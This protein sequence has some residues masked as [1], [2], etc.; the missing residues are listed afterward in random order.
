MTQSYRIKAAFAGVGIAALLSSNASAG[1]AKVVIDDKAP[2]AASEWSY[3][4]LFKSNT[5]Y[6]SDSGPINKIKWIG[7]YHG[8]YHSTDSNQGADSDWQNRRFR[9]GLQIEFLNDFKF[10]GQFNLKTD[11]SAGGRFVDSVEDLTIEWE[12]SDDF[13]VIVGKQKAKTTSDWATSSKQILTFERSLLTNQVVPDKIGGVVVGYNLTEKLWVEG[14]VFSG[15]WTDDGWELPDFNG[16]IAA[17]ARIGY[18]FNDATEL[19]FGYFYG[20]GAGEDTGIEEYDNVFVWSTVSS[21]GKVGLTTDIIYATGIDNSH[22]SDVFGLVIM[23]S[24]DIT[25]KLQAVFRY[26]YAQSESDSG[27]RLQSRYERAGDAAPLNTRGDSYNAFY[28]GL[29]YRLCGDNLKLM[30]GIEYADLAAPSAEDWDGF[31]YMAG[32]RLYF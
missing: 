12:P 2:V 8:Q 7:R 24:Y 28:L 23:P 20:E 32:V 5:L 9:A 25:E 13:Y 15:D 18:Q 17:S 30:G 10:E 22:N 31:T 21:W 19:R 4:D 16:G 11:Y 3:C 14:G 26:Q 29:N 27:I 1:D 6:K